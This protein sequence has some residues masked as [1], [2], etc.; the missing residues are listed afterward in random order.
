MSNDEHDLWCAPSQ[1]VLLFFSPSAPQ[2]LARDSTPE[3]FIVTSSNSG[4]HKT[5][6]EKCE[7][8]THRQ[9]CEAKTGRRPT[10]EKEVEKGGG[11]VGCGSCGCFSGSVLAG[12]CEE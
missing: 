5:S 11:L 4:H 7:R 12:C 3:S 8:R 1:I 2:V 9:E 10:A 6:W